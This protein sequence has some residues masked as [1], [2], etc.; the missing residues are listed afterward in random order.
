M[1]VKAIF[2]LICTLLALILM[3]CENERKWYIK[4]CGVVAALNAI[5][6]GVNL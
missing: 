3:L 2:Y 4:F 1:T 6:L 5:Y